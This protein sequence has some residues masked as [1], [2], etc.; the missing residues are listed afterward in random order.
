MSQTDVVT[1]AQEG[2][3]NAIAILINQALRG[4]GI[5]AKTIR[6]DQHLYVIL[7]AEELPDQS[8]CVRVIQNGM[9]RLGTTAIE[10]ITIAGQ[11]FNQNSPS[12]FQTLTL[13][14]IMGSQP[15]AN[16]FTQS[17]TPSSQ[18]QTSGKK[19]PK[20]LK[21]RF[22]LP[23]LQLPAITFPPP[24]VSVRKILTPFI[25]AGCVGLAFFPLSRW[26]IQNYEETFIDLKTETMHQWE[27]LPYR[28][29]TL[30]QT[31]QSTL[32]KLPTFPRFQSPPKGDSAPE[33]FP[34]T[35]VENLNKFSEIAL[36]TIQNPV[37]PET[38]IKLKAVGD[39][40]PGTNFPS[41]KLHPNKSVLF[42]SA[43]PALQGADILFGNFESTLTTHPKTA[44]NTNRRLVF[45]FRT[46]PSYTSI[47]QDAGFDVLSVA[48]NH[49]FDFFETG[50]ND[51]IENLNQAGMKAVGRKE[52]IVY[53][54]VKGVQFAFIGFSYFP[55]HNNMND[56]DAAKALVKK[57][58][59]NADIVVI[60]VHAGAEG[61]AA[62]NV[63]NKTEY[64]YGE[65]RGNKVLFSHTLIDEGADVI[66][67]HGP[68]VPRAM[69]LYK[70]K[71]IAYSLGNFMGY[72]TLS[73]RGKLGYSLVLEA[74]LDPV[75]NFTGGKIIPIHINSKGI[76][77]VDNKFR[78]VGLI[79]K[80]TQSNFPN[81]PL[82]IDRDGKIVVEE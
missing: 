21:K 76:P 73:S 61:T 59:E 31:V 28:F 7:E 62:L 3:A 46:P 27:S 39:I 68:H 2:N 53:H 23:S 77:Y 18:P 48:N 16:T 42:R 12:W 14:E 43:K 49:S 17:Q 80:L 37:S 1:L 6:R 65:N 10:L 70:G 26:M 54:E 69:E 67:G 38:R 51:T 30:S 19:T 71:L 5:T 22:R 40:I 82:T 36:S 8:A 32:E 20:K 9:L 33:D 55:V 75:G 15:A 11:Q 81:T 44:K 35:T 24:P 25:F 79:R 72:R 74:D 13:L 4:Q 45:A 29:T 63:R 56:L 66:L 41:N 52:D 47:L 60:S 50:F 78:S 64:F 57:A 34:E 58:D